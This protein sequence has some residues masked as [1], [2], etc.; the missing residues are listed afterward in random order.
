MNSR[1]LRDALFALVVKSP[2]HG[3]ELIQLVRAQGFEFGD[4]SVVYQQLR[5]M[6]RQGLLYST[7]ETQRG[8]PARRVY[9]AARH[10]V[11]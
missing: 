6:E 5:T 1:D 11:V 4:N 7:V 2:R 9:Q 10:E 3:Y 8:G